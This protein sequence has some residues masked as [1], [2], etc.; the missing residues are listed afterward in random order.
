MTDPRTLVSWLR[1]VVLTRSR[2]FIGHAAAAAAIKCPEDI[3]R[4][5][6]GHLSKQQQDDAN[7]AAQRAIEHWESKNAEILAG[8]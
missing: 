7:A 6:W 1:Q 5:A 2:P 3:V 8:R 4:E